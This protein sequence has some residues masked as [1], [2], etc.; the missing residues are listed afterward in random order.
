LLISSRGHTN[1][2]NHSQRNEHHSDTTLVMAMRGKAIES[3]VDC[4]GWLDIFKTNFADDTSNLYSTMEKD[5][6]VT[7]KRWRAYDMMHA[8]L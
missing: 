4:D 7:P 5:D 1:Y 3:A 2:G 6:L 8:A